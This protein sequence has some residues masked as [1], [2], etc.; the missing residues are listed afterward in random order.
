MV[1]VQQCDP[2]IELSGRVAP[3]HTPKEQDEETVGEA[4]R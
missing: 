1:T 3:V 4:A 2:P